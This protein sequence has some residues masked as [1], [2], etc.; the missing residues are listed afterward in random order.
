MFGGLI[1]YWYLTGD[2][3]FNDI[4]SQALL[5][6]VGPNADFMPQNQTKDEGNDDQSF[7]GMAAMSA[8]ENKF[9]NPPTGQ[10]QWLAMAQAVFNTQA[11][12]WDTQTCGGG[13]RWQIYTFNNGYTY[14]NTIANAC[15]FNIAARLGRY[16]GNATYFDWAN[17]A[18]NWMTDIGV[19][20]ADF[21]SYDG[22]DSL[23]NCTSINHIEWTY[24]NGALL[25][26]AAMMW[27][28]VS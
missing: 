27:N 21:H 6:Q 24:N 1:D 25:H 26:G 11:S 3:Q 5:F 12:R 8:A 15:F 17:K 20:S 19:V 22:T 13:L 23:Q 14:K 2:D 18:W 7:W 16:T 10:P 4:T 28:A 9:P